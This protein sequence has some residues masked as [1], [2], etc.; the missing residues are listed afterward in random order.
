MENLFVDWVIK[1]VE[2]ENWLVLVVWLVVYCGS[3]NCNI[4]EL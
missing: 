3:N 2:K 1:F 4:W